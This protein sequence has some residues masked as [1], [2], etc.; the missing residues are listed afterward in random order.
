[1]S[2][3]HDKGQVSGQ[4]GKI[5]CLGRE[6]DLELKFRR[7]TW[8]LVVAAVGSGKTT[9]FQNLLGNYRH[10]FEVGRD[11]GPSQL[12]LCLGQG[13]MRLPRSTIDSFTR[14]KSVVDLSSEIEELIESLCQYDR[15]VIVLDD[16]LSFESPKVIK[17]LRQL[18]HGSLRHSGVTLF[19]AV[20]DLKFIRDFSL[21]LPHANRCFF[22][23]NVANLDSLKKY[24]EKTYVDKGAREVLMK[25]LVDL[26]NQRVRQKQYDC[27]AFDTEHMIAFL[28][29]QTEVME[30]VKGGGGGG[31]NQ[32]G[33][34]PP[35]VICLSENMKYYL[36][37][38]TSAKL[39]GSK[40]VA[41]DLTA[42]D[43]KLADLLLDKVLSGLGRKELDIVARQARQ[44]TPEW[45]EF[46]TFLSLLGKVAVDASGTANDTVSPVKDPL[47]VD[48]ASSDSW[49]G[50]P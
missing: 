23:G 50:F 31:G 6:I 37:E 38:Q 33:K 22:M 47:T 26:H 43:R 25:H 45:P 19:M 34:T 17:G 2:G 13:R 7:G 5:P 18:L 30:R 32:A 44:V 1:M 9:F 46:K 10:F 35:S 16:F 28:N 27:I 29:Y 41:D 3:D 11:A 12:V 42:R 21:F 40:K 4:A 49:G 48:E 8:H 24:C 39:V 14:T 36:V 15:S 20:H